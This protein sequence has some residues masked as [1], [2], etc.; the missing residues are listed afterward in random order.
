MDVKHIKERECFTDKLSR[1][2]RGDENMAA[3]K[4]SIM[5]DV[6]KYISELQKC[7]IPVLKTWLLQRIQS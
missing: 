6:K 7:G 3:S 2:N 5:N 4:D 1:S